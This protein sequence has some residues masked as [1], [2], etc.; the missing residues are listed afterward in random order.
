MT[1]NDV[2]KAAK[3]S[4]STVSKVINNHPS[5]SEAT[6]RRIRKVMKE[7]HFTPDF[8]A[9]NLAKG[10]HRNVT[11]LMDVS[12]NTVFFEPFFYAIVGGVESYMF[13]QEYD[14]TISHLGPDWKTEQIVQRFVANKKNNGILLPSSLLNQ[15][16]VQELQ[17]RNFPFVIIGDP[18][19]FRHLHW[20]D[21]HNARGSELA[22]KHFLQRG[23]D[24]I[25]F[26][27]AGLGSALF[28]NRFRGYRQAL[29]DS[30]MPVRPEYVKPG[31]ENERGAY[32]FMQELLALPEPPD[33][34]LCDDNYVAYAALQAIREA[35]RSI[36]DD[37][38]VIA[39]NNYP[40][41]AYLTPPVTA[42]DIDTFEL[43]VTA[44]KTLLDILKEPGTKPKTILIEPSLVIRDSTRRLECGEAFAKSR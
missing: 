41:A 44:A 24:R 18:Q 28:E 16:L 9:K 33:A 1:I 35:G 25:A 30:G 2:A 10:G 43:G 14:L 31:F 29:E 39:F 22:V 26:I 11:L 21:V 3:V 17:D 38:G 12:R 23:Y 4:K 6:K 42:I 32:K 19:E 13:M 27:A 37:M 5:I 15:E 34:V 7:L 20:I 40:L 36:P 8:L